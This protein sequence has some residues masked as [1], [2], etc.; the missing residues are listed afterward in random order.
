MPAIASPPPGNVVPA[1]TVVATAGTNK[2]RYV[3]H[4]DATIKAGEEAARAF[5]RFKR[6]S[7]P[8]EPSPAAVIGKRLL[9]PLTVEADLRAFA[10]SE[11][12]DFDALVAGAAKHFDSPA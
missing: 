7:F 1:Y 4:A 2:V 11:G 10:A 3:L 6:R 5:V 12:V 9:D 8:T